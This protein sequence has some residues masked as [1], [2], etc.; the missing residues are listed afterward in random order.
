MNQMAFEIGWA[1]DRA[2]GLWNAD[3]DELNNTLRRSLHA[4]DREYRV[5]LE[6]VHERLKRS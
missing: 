3:F 6:L 2:D 4:K 5:P 1:V